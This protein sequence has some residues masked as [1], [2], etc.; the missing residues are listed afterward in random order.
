LHE[1][2]AYHRQPQKNEDANF[3][4]QTSLVPVHL[5]TLIVGLTADFR[6]VGAGSPEPPITHLIVDEPGLLRSIAPTFRATEKEI[7]DQRIA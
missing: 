2:R 7:L 6:K 4:F 5:E 1:E 3:E